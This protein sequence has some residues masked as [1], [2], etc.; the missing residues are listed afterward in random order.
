MKVRS[1]SIGIAAF[2]A[3][4]TLV[5]T[6]IVSAANAEGAPAVSADP[7][8]TQ[9][10][11][12]LERFEVA[13]DVQDKLV[14]KFLRGESLDAD[15]GAIPVSESTKT[16][17]GQRVTRYVYADGSVAQ[18]SL[19]LPVE[20]GTGPRAIAG[21]NHTSRNGTHEYKGCKVTWDAVSWSGGMV[22][23]Y[24]YYTF[25]SFVTSVTGA[26][27]EGGG[28]ISR[29]PSEIPVPSCNSSCVSWGQSS[30]I[31]KLTVGGL[32]ITRTIGIKISVN[33]SNIKGGKSSSFG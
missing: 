10:V 20:G 14:A 5:A 31:Q 6:G 30:A 9:L 8:V 26:W 23:D 1:L 12:T 28:D 2:G 7:A 24:G 29:N 22:A 19:A 17:D 13:P 3:A 25:G 15:K 33:N 21:C 18:S 32:G 16:V 11:T 4:A 27:F